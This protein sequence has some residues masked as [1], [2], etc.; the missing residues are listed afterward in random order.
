[1][2]NEFEQLERCAQN[3]LNVQPRSSTISIPHIFSF[4][5]FNG[6][7]SR[8]QASCVPLHPEVYNLPSPQLAPGYCYGQNDAGVPNARP[9]PVPRG[10]FPIARAQT[11]SVRLQNTANDDGTESISTVADS[12]P[13]TEVPQNSS[14]IGNSETTNPVS[15]AA[16]ENQQA[17]A[18]DGVSDL[19]FARFIQSELLLTS[20][21]IQVVIDPRRAIPV[22]RQW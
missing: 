22:P 21:R 1:M 17:C 19:V 7:H 8:L 14:R 5:T 12:P 10:P 3:Y 9:E 11:A 13:R 4:T 6:P 15:Q 18:K 20:L 16:P 2:K